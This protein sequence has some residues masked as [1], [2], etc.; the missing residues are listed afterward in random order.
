[1]IQYK[2]DVSQDQLKNIL[3]SRSYLRKSSCYVRYPEEIAIIAWTMLFSEL[4]FT[5]HP[6]QGPAAE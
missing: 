5:D 4:A 1:M 2:Q 3:L 6:A